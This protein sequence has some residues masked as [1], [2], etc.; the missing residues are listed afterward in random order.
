MNTTKTYAAKSSV[1]RAMKAQGIAPE[2]YTIEQNNEGQFFA[3]MVAAKKPASAGK[4]TKPR[5]GN[6]LHV[7]NIADAMRDARRKDVIAA[8][9]EQGIN[10][11]TASTQ[12]Q[13][14]FAANR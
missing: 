8:C 12:Y 6:C 5:N 7:W 1:T 9:V 13:Q 11:G 3:K 2:A 10:A 14:W 4:G